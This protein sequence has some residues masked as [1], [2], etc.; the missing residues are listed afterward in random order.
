VIR[1]YA[2]PKGTEAHTQQHPV[3]CSRLGLTQLTASQAGFG[4]YR[5]SVG[6]AH[7]EKAL[8]R[9]ECGRIEVDGVPSRKN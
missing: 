3:A 8:R 9:A 4:C 7:H 5:V 6:I 2:T 1:G